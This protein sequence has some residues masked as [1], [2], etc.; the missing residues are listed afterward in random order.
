MPDKKR[1]LDE[2][3]VK[4]TERIATLSDEA[5]DYENPVFGE[6]SVDARILFIGEAPGGDEVKLKR[7]FVGK[8]G[9][10]LDRMLE[11][12]GIGRDELFVT[13]SVKYRPWKKSVL[14]NGRQSTRN[15][16]PSAKEIKASAEML[17]T[18]L[19]VIKP[20]IVVTLG[21]SPLFAVQHIMNITERGGIG[22]L[23]GDPVKLS[24]G[25]LEFCLFPLYHPASGIYNR[26]LVAVMEE[27]L[28]K[29]ASFSKK[30]FE[31]R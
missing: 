31:E 26:S 1:Q 6:G 10:Q 9:K 30:D 18:E 24:N 5:G 4:E 19:C 29:L 8:A 2:A 21:N 23:H 13:N 25:E 16:T 12:C 14:A 11:L 20:N 15:R 3:R 7:P 27:D 17:R 28:M 22:E